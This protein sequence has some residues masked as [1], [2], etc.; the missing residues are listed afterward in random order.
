M[1]S[2][3]SGGPRLNMRIN[4]A[5]Y[6]HSPRKLKRSVWY[7]YTV[8]TIKTLGLV[9][10]YYCWSISLTFY[11]KWIFTEFHFPLTLTIIHFFI[12]FLISIPVRACLG[13]AG[14]PQP[15]TLDWGTYVR[16]VAPTAVA[17]SLDIGLSNWS[18]VF[19]TIS[20]YTMSKSSC[21]VF[22]L[23]FAILFRL[24]K[25]KLVQ[26]VIILFIAVGLFM[27]TYHSTQFNLEGFILVMI[28][29]FIG[30]VRWSLAQLLT[31]NKKIGLVNPV[32]TIYHL[33]PIMIIAL[34]PIAVATEGLKVVST[35]QFLAYTDIA[36]FTSMGFKIC[37]GAVLAFF[38]AC[39]E[40]LLVSMTSSLT[41]S[42][43]GIFKEVCTL[44]LAVHFHGDVLST[45]NKF[46]MVVCLMGIVVHVGM[47][48]RA[49]KGE[50][51]PKLY[52][53][54]RNGEA[55]Q[56]LLREG[57]PNDSASDE[58]E[59]FTRNMDNCHRE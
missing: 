6:E 18:L 31:Q 19:I 57:D 51:K 55:V 28:A 37:L 42:I 48:A 17:S 47:K 46:G 33:Q 5:I 16:N 20:L 58:D 24:E 9:L 4:Q 32:D 52:T 10:F 2:S 21:I 34:L 36:E 27:F 7:D 40:Y 25:P 38:L 45:L 39:S 41:L 30:G 12:K 54:E 29:S 43:S 35:K 22:L 56:M 44:T 14:G 59:I 8:M 1:T 53:D 50:K 15:V 23:L 13:K 26:G 49:S 3:P 11:N